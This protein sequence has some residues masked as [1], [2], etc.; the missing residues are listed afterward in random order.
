M[1]NLNIINNFDINDIKKNIAEILPYISLKND[2]ENQK[3]VERMERIVV[4]I[5][6]ILSV[7][8]FL[9]LL[10]FCKK[11]N[12]FHWVL[13]I[14]ISF[15]LGWMIP[16]FLLFSII[17]P[18]IDKNTTKKNREMLEEKAEKITSLR[19]AVEVISALNKVFDKYTIKRGTP[20]HDV[21][22]L[23]QLCRYIQT[24]LAVTDKNILKIHFTNN[25]E[26]LL[27]IENPD[28]HIVEKREFFITTAKN[29]SIQNPELIFTNWEQPKL[30]QRYEK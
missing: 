16:A 19:D 2:E 26:L 12:L 15:V 24:Y 4:I 8:A 23:S 6:C 3:Q 17:I 5:S 1:N 22:D 13:L 14:P 30:I 21:Y 11:D 7:I 20:K 10:L 27:D 25:N 28:T 9:F 18:A 29:T